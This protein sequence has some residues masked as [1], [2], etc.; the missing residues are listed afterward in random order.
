MGELASHVA[1]TIR[2]ESQ[3]EPERA[4]QA[5]FIGK[6]ARCFIGFSSPVSCRQTQEQRGNAKYQKYPSEKLYAVCAWSYR[7]AIQSNQVFLPHISDKIRWRTRSE[8]T[9]HWHRSPSDPDGRKIT[10]LC[11]PG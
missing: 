3:R 6:E 4:P 9:R 8:R 10:W 11:H 5:R 2:R 7:S 1:R